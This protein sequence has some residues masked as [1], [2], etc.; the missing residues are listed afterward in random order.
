M[1]IQGG[2]LLAQGLIGRAWRLNQGE[3]LE[4]DLKDKFSPEEGTLMFWVRP[5]WD[6]AS[7]QSHTLVSFSWSGP[8]RAYGAITRG[9]WEPAGAQRTYFILNNQDYAHVSKLIDYEKGWTHLACTWKA[10]NPGFLR[11]YVNGFR[12][13]DG[14]YTSKMRRQLASPVIIGSDQGSPLAKSRWAEADLDELA[15][16]PQALSDEEIFQTFLEQRPPAKGLPKMVDGKLLETRAIF[17]EGIGWA[18]EAGAQKTIERIKQ[19]GFNVYVPCVWHGRGTRYPS[20]KA[21]PEPG[22]TILTTDPLKR[23]IELAHAQ[24]IEVHPWFCVALRQRD[25]LPEFFGPGTPDK[26]FDLHRPQFRNFIVEVILDV[27]R[28]YEVDGI[29]L[30]YIRTMGL[31]RC[32]FCQAEYRRS[33]GRDLLADIASLKPGMSLPPTLQKWQDEAVEDIVRQ[34]KE[35][36]KAIKPGLIISVCGHPQL[37]PSPEGRDELKWANA[38][39]IDVIFNMDYRKVPD[40]DKFQAIRQQ[41]KDPSKLIMLLGNYDKKESGITATESAHLARVLEYLQSRWPGRVGIYLYKQLS[42][43]QVEAL[44]Q[45]PF[46]EPA[47]P[48]WPTN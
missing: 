35:K 6:N 42:D 10:G 31:C 36:G 18:T 48:A 7:P 9:W 47:R 14:H 19:A 37:K 26:A 46:R 16:F 2:N 41:L 44:A 1:K 38:G 34:V 21:P 3:Y 4:L 30:D 25:F 43:S 24:G 32:E 40:F 22:F 5:H 27:I 45:G 12:T 15:L 29:N 13:A 20:S 11:F 8:D 17:D 39:L 33:F 23:L 28:R